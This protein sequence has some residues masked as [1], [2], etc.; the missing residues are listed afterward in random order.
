MGNN[1]FVSMNENPKHTAGWLTTFNDL[2]TLLMVFFVLIFSMSTID[3]KRLKEF[4]TSLQSGLGVLK[5]GRKA[6]I[7]VV[8]PSPE[9]RDQESGQPNDTASPPQPVHEGMEAT[10]EDMKN[11]KGVRASYSSEGVLFTVDEELLF[12]SGSAQIPD[13]RIPVLSRIAVFLRSMPYPVR[14]EGHTDNVPIHNQTYPS[15]WELS[16]ARSIHVLKYFTEVEH[17]EPQRFAAVG[18]G[19]AKPLY[20]NDSAQRRAQ[21]RRV[22]ILM[23]TE[24]EGNHVE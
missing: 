14:I 10:L 17:L 2:T 1:I 23:V 9:S 24:D 12:V 19:D 18:Y 5:E 3:A 21:N 4:Q 15:N 13:G 11:I 7:R 6:A 20:P 22:E 16:V 8:Q